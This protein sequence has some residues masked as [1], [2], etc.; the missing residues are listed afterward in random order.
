M[1]L[2]EHRAIL[3]S[4]EVRRDLTGGIL[5]LRVTAGET[6]RTVLTPDPDRG[7]VTLPAAMRAGAVVLRAD[8]GR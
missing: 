3:A 1:R 6:W 4:P 8:L 7:A 2:R 5:R